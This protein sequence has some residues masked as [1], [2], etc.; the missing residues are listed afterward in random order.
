MLLGFESAGDICG[1]LSF[2]RN[3]P[4]LKAFKSSTTSLWIRMRS[5]VYLSAVQTPK[6]MGLGL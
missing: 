6:F 5:G 1:L 4:A 3:R 2:G